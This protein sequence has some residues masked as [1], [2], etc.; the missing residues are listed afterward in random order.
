M[1]AGRNSSLLHKCS[2]PE[3]AEPL[4]LCGNMGA[5]EEICP[6]PPTPLTD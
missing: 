3:L 5:S 2:V 4:H 6:A 1:G